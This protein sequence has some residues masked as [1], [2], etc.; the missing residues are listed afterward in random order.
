MGGRAE[1]HA[2]D[3]NSE[4]GDGSIEMPGYDAESLNLLVFG[5]ESYAHRDRLLNVAADIH[6]EAYVDTSGIPGVHHQ[7]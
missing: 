7:R 6:A 2:R 4:A 3:Q 5:V 1:H